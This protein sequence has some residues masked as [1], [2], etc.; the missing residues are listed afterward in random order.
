MVCS[1]LFSR[2]YSIYSY[3]PIICVVIYKKNLD[4]CCLKEKVLYYVK[5]W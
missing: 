1:I 5:R 3:I 2:R 4:I